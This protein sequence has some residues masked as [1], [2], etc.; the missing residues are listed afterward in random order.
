MN[1]PGRWVG[2]KGQI[3]FQGRSHDHPDCGS[4]KLVSRQGPNRWLV[5]WTAE[6]D[7]D[8]FANNQSTLQFV[9]RE[10]YERNF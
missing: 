4:Y 7:R 6:C 3:D 8:G 5:E 10:R 9:S 1:I 2:A